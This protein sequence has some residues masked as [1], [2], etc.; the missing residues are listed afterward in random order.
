MVVIIGGVNFLA[1][2]NS[3][4][5]LFEGKNTPLEY[6]IAAS[7]L[8]CNMG[9]N[10]YRAIDKNMHLEKYLSNGERVGKI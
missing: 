7:P 6:A 9:V 1:F 3:G 10:I 5:Q 2:T 4:P 8:V